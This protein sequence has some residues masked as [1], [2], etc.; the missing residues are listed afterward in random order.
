MGGSDKYSVLAGRG[1]A[2]SGIHTGQAMESIADL[3]P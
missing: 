3:R 2:L 1:G